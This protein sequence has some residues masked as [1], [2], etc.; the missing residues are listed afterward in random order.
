MAVAETARLVLYAFQWVW[1]VVVLGVI[2]SQLVGLAPL[3]DGS[4][5]AKFC[6]LNWTVGLSRCNF[7]VRA[8]QL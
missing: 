7:G 1:T 3:A 6:K 2:P 5:N 8:T 4:G